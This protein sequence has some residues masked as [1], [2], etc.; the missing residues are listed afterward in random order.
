MRGVNAEMSRRQPDHDHR[1][2][3]F[4]PSVPE[5]WIACGVVEGMEMVTPAP[6]HG[7]ETAIQ[8]AKPAGKMA[9]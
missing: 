7:L 9:P 8:L 2:Q 4:Q 3:R 5:T 1:Q 6:D